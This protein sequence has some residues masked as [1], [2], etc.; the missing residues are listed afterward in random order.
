M[1][2]AHSMLKEP[3]QRYA[4][5]DEFAADLDRV[6]RGLVPVAA[7]AMMAAVPHE[8]T[9]FVPAAEATRI[10]PRPGRRRS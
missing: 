6:R 8:P 4:S 7:T 10:A 3:T 5:A 2:V 9:E 1:V